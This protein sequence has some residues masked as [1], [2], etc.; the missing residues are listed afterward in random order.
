[1]YRIAVTNRKL[2]D[3]D[4]LARIRELAAGSYYQAIMLR[5]KDLPETEYKVLAKEV[6]EICKKEEKICI[7]HSYPNVAMEFGHPYLHLPLPVW[8]KMQ[9]PERQQLRERMTKMGTSVH[10][11]E[12]L[13]KA[14]LLGAD[15]VCAG[16]IFTTDCKKDLPPRGLDFLREM[17]SDSPV[18]VYAIGGIRED[19]E[20][21]TT[22]QGAA[23]V[24]I[25]SG[26]MKGIV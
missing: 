23:G 4:F 20:Y 10:S 19:N 3:G 2:C 26:S 15:Y 18:P 9:R 12:Q 1:M 16:H 21:L 25:M 17:C 6:L 14:L 5:E 7:L 11:K 8:E 22:K 13:H 24:C